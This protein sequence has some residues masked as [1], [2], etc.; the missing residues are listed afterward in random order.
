MVT[1]LAAVKASA[2]PAVNIVRLLEMLSE[3]SSEYAFDELTINSLTISSNP[4]YEAWHVIYKVLSEH[5][6]KEH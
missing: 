6:N 4:L 2:T 3:P 5:G 1:I